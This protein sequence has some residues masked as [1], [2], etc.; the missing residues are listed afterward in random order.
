ARKSTTCC[1]CP[2]WSVDPLFCA[3]TNQQWL[4]VSD[5][6]YQIFHDASPTS[7]SFPFDD[8]NSTFTCA[9]KKEDVLVNYTVTF[10]PK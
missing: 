5:L 3:G 2:S 4:A 6:Y 10:C 9:G 8:F 7:Y 1:G